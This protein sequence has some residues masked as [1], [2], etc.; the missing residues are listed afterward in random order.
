MKLIEDSRQKAEKHEIKH[1]WFSLHNISLFRSKLAFGDYALPPAA[2]VD[3]KQNLQEIAGNMCGSAREKKR[4]REECKLAKECGSKLIVLIEDERV[5]S[6][7]D[8]YGKSIWLMSKQIIKGDQLAKAMVTMHERYDVDFMF[9]KP[10]DS[11][12]TIIKLLEKYN[13][14]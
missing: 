7:D 1:N 13:N 12:E 6:V 14:G 5:Q 2:A 11:A 3:T 10:E 8:L 9:C 4:F